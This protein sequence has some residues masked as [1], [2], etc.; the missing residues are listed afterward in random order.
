MPH[1]KPA[2]R[3]FVGLLNKQV[4]VGS[5]SPPRF[6][7]VSLVTQSGIGFADAIRNT[8]PV[9]A[10]PIPSSDSR[11]SHRHREANREPP[12]GLSAGFS[13]TDTVDTYLRQI[14]THPLLSK[15][16]EY[17]WAARLDRFRHR[18]RRELLSIG[19]VADQAVELLQQSLDGRLRAD[20]VLDFCASDHEA[21]D[22]IMGRLTH[23]LRTLNALRERHRRSISDLVVHAVGDQA[24]QPI[25]REA[26]RKLARTRRKIIQLIEEAK[27]RFEWFEDLIPEVCCFRRPPSDQTDSVSVLAIQ[28]FEEPVATIRTRLQRIRRLHR[29]YL[30]ARQTLTESNLRLVV[31]LAKK[32]VGRGVSLVDL[33]QEGNFGLMRAVEKFDHRRGF[34][35]STYATWW[36][37]QALFR[38]T[39]TQGRAIA[40]PQHALKTMN[41]LLSEAER[42]G[43]EMGYRPTRSELSQRMNVSEK[44]LKQ[45]E[46]M[47]A[48]VSSYVRDSVQEKAITSLPDEDA[49]RADVQV[50]LDELRRHVPE[51]LKQLNSREREVLMMRFGL[52]QETS[53]TLTQIGQRFGIGRER[54]RQIEKRAMEKLASCEIARQLVE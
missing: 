54:V 24:S 52:D 30:T 26:I 1:G 22:S 7:M 27:I 48:G 11:Q 21:K 17:Q 41:S 23:N 37:R 33:I 49:V 8:I 29:G 20:R 4:I 10:E 34:K 39:A 14:A 46:A 28:D 15:E 51:L 3:T 12:G 2:A 31:S 6:P 40:M 42:I 47:S 44:R 43:T 19:V 38:S 13:G 5:F 32:H 35:F 18:L 25:G 9:S 45:A 53:K 16:Q 36:I 50:H